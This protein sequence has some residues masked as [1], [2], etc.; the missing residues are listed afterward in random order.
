MGVGRAIGIRKR[1]DHV[2]FTSEWEGATPATGV[3]VLP[4]ASCITGGVGGVA[5]AA[6]LT[7]EAPSGRQREIWY[8][9][10]I[11][12]GPY[13]RVTSA[14]TVGEGVYHV[15]F[16]SEWG[17]CH[18]SNWRDGIAARIASPVVLE[19]LHPLHS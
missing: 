16:A 1:I 17:W 11:G 18:T 5:S 12:I 7:V 8:I 19:V 2:A 4:H 9:D 13:M 3:I 10:R 6:Q 15:A 14:I